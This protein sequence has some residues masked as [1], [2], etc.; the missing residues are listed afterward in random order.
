M[1]STVTSSSDPAPAAPSARPS[2]ESF[3][4]IKQGI[5]SE[6]LRAAGLP[7]VENLSYDAYVAA[8]NRKAAELRAAEPAAGPQ[9]TGPAPRAKA[10]T[11]RG[12]A[13]RI[14][15]A[16]FV[17]VPVALVFVLLVA[18]ILKERP[19]GTVLSSGGEA[20][21][22]PLTG[23]GLPVALAITTMD[24]MPALSL[25]EDDAPPAPAAVFDHEAAVV[26]STAEP[27]EF[28][29]VMP[30]AKPMSAAPVTQKKAAARESAK[31]NV[32]PAQE[33]RAASAK[34]E[35]ATAKPARRAAKDQD[36]FWQPLVDILNGKGLR[37]ARNVPAP[38]DRAGK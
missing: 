4:R 16:S 37:G 29:P 11:D 20:I 12:D 7:A 27:V 3:L 36:D 32:L 8:I 14:A 38:E 19:D 25:S 21:A 15:W 5:G 22:A 18:D 13:K 34:A 24:E 6:A 33:R 10:A 28:L 2:Y 26:P 30:I 31:A 23:D 17:A 9:A 35:K 1:T